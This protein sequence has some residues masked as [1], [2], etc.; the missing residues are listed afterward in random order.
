MKKKLFLISLILLTT[1]AFTQDI[2]GKWN[3]LLKL[4]GFELRVGFNISNTGN[5]IF[6]T[7]DSPDQGAFGIEMTSAEFDGKTIK[8]THAAATIVYI[9]TLNDN[10]EIKGTFTQAGQ[11]FPLDLVRKTIERTVVSK[12]QDPVKPYPYYC[13][14]VT[15]HNIKDKVD[16]SGTLTMPSKKGLFPAVVLIS[17]SGPQNRDE[18]LLGH[19]PFLILSDYLTRNGIAVLRF[20]DR[21]T[22]ESTGDFSKATSADFASDVTACVDYL[23]TRT[24]IN[25]D[26]IGLIGH[27]EGGIIAP[28]VAAED[29]NI[30]FI[31]LMAGTGVRGDELLLMQ[32]E[33]I[34]K[35]SGVSPE[36]LEKGRK[37]N[38]KIFDIVLEN[39]D[40]QLLKSKLHDYLLS[41]VNE[42]PASQKSKDMT[43]EQMVEMIINQTTT[44]WMQYFIRH[45]PAVVLEQVRCPVLAINGTKDLQVPS[46]VNLEAIRAS[47]TKGDNKNF[48][49]TELEGLNHLFQ[50]CTTGNPVEYSNI[51]QTISPQALKAMLDWITK[52]TKQ[53]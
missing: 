28:M 34:G 21:G 42:I 11:V 9:G 36:E 32:Q 39:N 46:E 23:K 15:I 20:D 18:E 45:D 13:E 22:N 19:K 6:A 41:A 49:I 52:V 7:M 5:A 16:L 12:P 1:T 25:G 4:P 51:E 44:P 26:Q 33:A 37:L 35:V 31:I 40:N 27:S 43:D 38:R 50:E 8:I 30:G 17:G 3:G 2:T 47:L 14:E 24:E 53:I 29:N 10:G 48:T